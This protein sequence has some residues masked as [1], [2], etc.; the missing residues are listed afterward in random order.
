MQAVEW[1]F[2]RRVCPFVDEVQAN[3]SRTQK[4]RLQNLPLKL[5]PCRSIVG[6][7]NSLNR[8]CRVCF[9]HR[10]HAPDDHFAQIRDRKQCSPRPSVE[11]RSI[12]DAIFKASIIVREPEQFADESPHFV[13]VVN[14]DLHVGRQNLKALYGDGH[15]VVD[16]LAGLRRLATWAW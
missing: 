5:A 4:R 6:S 13:V 14:V 2:E 7:A 8:P 10:R 12:T 1:A 16:S 15:T 11:R 3:F 9:L